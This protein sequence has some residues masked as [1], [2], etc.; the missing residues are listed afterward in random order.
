M[1]DESARDPLQLLGR[2]AGALRLDTLPAEVV[3]R[4]KQRVLDT[5]GCLVAGYHAG[6]AAIVR[7]YVLAQGGKPEVTL[8]PNGEKTTAA[9]AG[10]AHA[11]YI[12]GLE[13]SDAADDT[14]RERSL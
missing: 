3:Q 14:L 5:V 6:V 9:L 4:A 13:L 7:D 11:A 12:F 10:F 8:L 2:A 1:I